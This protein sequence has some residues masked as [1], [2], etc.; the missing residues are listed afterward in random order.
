MTRAA[1]AGAGAAAAACW[2]GTAGGTGGGSWE[3]AKG[4]EAGAAGVATAVAGA[5]VAK[6]EVAVTGASKG[7]TALSAAKGERASTGGGSPA[8]GR[9]SGSF[10][11]R[12]GSGLSFGGFSSR[13]DAN[14]DSGSDTTAKGLAAGPSSATAKGLLAGGAG[15]KP[16]WGSKIPRLLFMASDFVRGMVRSAASIASRMP[17]VEHPNTGSQLAYLI[18]QKGDRANHVPSLTACPYPDSVGCMSVFQPKPKAFKKS[19]AR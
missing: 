12:P 6:G 3:K 18:S 4:E 8:T 5:A 15:A 11:G 1:G 19:A 10:T 13:R 7:E 17:K 14:G 16:S 9:R 2:T